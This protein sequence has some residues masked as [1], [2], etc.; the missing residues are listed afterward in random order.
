MPLPAR[1]LGKG[2]VIWSL[3]WLSSFSPE[4]AGLLPAI[5]AASSVGAGFPWLN[6]LCWPLKCDPLAPGRFLQL[7]FGYRVCSEAERFL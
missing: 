3:W 5:S 6:W 1:H 2:A 4:S 7:F